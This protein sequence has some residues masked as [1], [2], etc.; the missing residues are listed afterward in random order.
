[1]VLPPPNTPEGAPPLPLVLPLQF[2]QSLEAA[3][4]NGGSSPKLIK[5][6]QILRQHF[7]VRQPPWAVWQPFFAS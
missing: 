3:V 7:S 5:L 4:R 2:Q 6:V 1:M